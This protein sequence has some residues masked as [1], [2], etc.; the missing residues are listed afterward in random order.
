MR[1]RTGAALALAGWA[2]CGGERKT[3]GRDG[4]ARAALRRHPQGA[5]HP[6]L[7]LREDRRRA[8]GEGTRQRRDRVA[9]ARD[10]RPAAAEGDPRVVHHAAR[11]RHRDLGAQRRLPHRDDQPRDRRGHPGRHLGLRRAEIEAASPSTASTTS[12][13]AGSWASRR[14]SCSNGKGKVAIITSVGA[15][16]LQRRLDGV[17]EALAKAPGIEIVEIYDIKEDAVRCAEIIA[18]GIAPLPR[19]RRVALA[20]AAGRSSRATRSRRRSGEDQGD[21]VRHGRKPALRCCAKAR[22]RC[23]SARSTSAG[24]ANR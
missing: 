23:S 21:L 17:R 16:N 24:A 3:P 19:S 15:T 2:A 18:T 11:R 8:G 13:R 4:A 14:S 22:C 10:G 5:R 1:R 9:R 20:S 7:Q 12:R 6:R